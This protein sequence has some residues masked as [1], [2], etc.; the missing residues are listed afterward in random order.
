MSENSPGLGTAGRLTRLALKRLL[1]HP[2]YKVLAVASALGVWLYVQGTEVVQR[3]FNVDVTWSLPAG[4]VTV[5]PLPTSV[6]LTIEGPHNGVRRASRG[7]ASMHVDLSETGNMPREDAIDFANYEIK[8]LPQTVQ[9]LRVTP[10]GV[11]LQLDELISRNVEVNPVTVGEPAEG[12]IVR[13]VRLEPQ[14][15]ALQ[16]PR[17]RMSNLPTIDTLPIDVSE[18]RHDRRLPAE[19]DLPRGV[20]LVVDAALE[21]RVDIEARVTGRIIEAVPIQVRGTNRW[22]AQEGTVRVRLE[23][24]AASVQQI[25][26]EDVI[27]LVFLPEDP[28]GNSYDVSFSA[29]EG[30]R[31]TVIVPSELVKAVSTE[32]NII[33]VVRQ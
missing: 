10:A 5:H 26:D 16:G 12:Y 20:E 8:D 3:R 9:L 33:K 2:H 25:R 21:A 4:L 1:Q 18:L 6:A 14:V 7:G 22:V 13:D 27:A 15:L 23:G 32:P 19:L 28:V 31:A 11:R 17:I 30:V 24:P 29:V